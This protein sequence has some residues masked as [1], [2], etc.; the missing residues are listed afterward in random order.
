MSEKIDVVDGKLK[1]TKES[2]VV[3]STMEREEVVGRIA[4]EQTKA[5]HLQLDLT[6]AQEEVAKWDDYLKEMDK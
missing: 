6:A 1:I 3:V 5:D 2:D 4:E